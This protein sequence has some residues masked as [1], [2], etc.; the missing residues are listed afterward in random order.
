MK[1][2]LAFGLIK[3]I[4]I[5]VAFMMAGAGAAPLKIGVVAGPHAMIMEKVKE[6]AKKA[7]LELQLV[8]FNDFMLPN[9]A[10]NDKELDANSYQHNPYLVE[11][12]KALGYKLVSIG[13][14]VLMPLG[15][16]PGKVKALADLKDGDQ[17]AIPNDPTNGGRA[18]K[19][20]EKAALLTLK[21]CDN[22]TP[23]DIKDNPKN[24]KI[25]ELE[26]PQLPRSLEDVAMAVI[27]TDW[28]ILA[29]LDPKTAVIT[30]EKDS[31][32]ANII[33]TREGEESRA[34]L[35]QL[36]DIYHSKEIRAY[37]EKEFKGA[38]ITAW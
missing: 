33:A 8:E 37:I 30:E 21:P 2:L 25:I 6:E 22:P 9:K 29:K 19:L 12:N 15:A 36:V 31:P 27:N 34:E 7:G 20:L 10:L 17:I 1:K 3:K 32:Y 26:S 18:L 38:V 13:K 5:L 16:Y 11:Q 28:V 24:L 4:I 35:R 23:L 14:T